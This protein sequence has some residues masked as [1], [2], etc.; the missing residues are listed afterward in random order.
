M[1]VDLVIRASKA[2]RER[3]HEVDFTLLLPPQKW[4]FY[5]LLLIP[6][7]RRSP[8]PGNDGPRMVL[9]ELQEREI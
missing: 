3:R 7:S 1:A 5:P 4:A 6:S 2:M 8:Q 9:M